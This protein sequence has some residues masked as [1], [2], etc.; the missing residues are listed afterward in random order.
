MTAHCSAMERRDVFLVGRRWI[1]ATCQHRIEHLSVST[2]SRAVEHH[3]M[4]IAKIVAQMWRTRE[5]RFRL[6]AIA[7]R[8]GGDETIERR[9][10]IDGAMCEEPGGN[11]V[12]PV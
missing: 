2:F 8:T 6:H 4:L 1:E 11:V 12:I 10:F 7:S 9:E 5:H 3:V